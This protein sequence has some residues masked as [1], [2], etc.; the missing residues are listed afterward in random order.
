MKLVSFNMNKEYS[1]K[2]SNKITKSLKTCLNMCC[3]KNLRGDLPRKRSISPSNS[4]YLKQRRAKFDY[5]PRDFPENFWKI[6][7]YPDQ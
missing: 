6:R 2:L 5:H 1:K 4:N 3:L 7:C